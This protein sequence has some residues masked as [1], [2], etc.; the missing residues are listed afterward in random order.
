MDIDNAVCVGTRWARFRFAVIGPLLASVAEHGQLA[1]QL[2]QLAGRT[3]QHPSTGEPVRFSVST[4]ERWYY[5]AKCSPVDPVGAL[6]TKPNAK[7]GT[8]PSIPVLL[9]QAIR[10]QYQ[11]H[12][13]WS[14]QLHYD[15]LVALCRNSPELAPV[16][17]YPTVRR[18]MQSQGL[19]KQRRR[20][21]QKTL[22]DGSGQIQQRETRSYESPYVNALWHLD[23]H[24][25]S[26]RVLTAEGHYV[27]PYL[28][29]V[30]DDH[31]RLCP[32]LQWY[33]EQTA[34]WL[35]HALSQAFLKR[36]LCRV[37]LTDNGSAMIAAETVQGL[38][39]LGICH[40]TTLPRSPEQNGKQEV[41][42]AQVEGRL[43]PM[44]EGEKPLTLELLNR[45]THAWVEQEYNRKVHSETGQA[46]LGRFLNDKNVSRPCPDADTLRKYF[47]AQQRRTQ[48]LSDG[49]VSAMGVRFE[50]PWRYRTLQHPT[51]RF[52]RWDL[53]SIDLVDPHTDKLLCT[54]YPIDK[55]QNAQERRRPV[56]PA[57]EVHLQPS[58]A[59]DA[60]IAPLLRQL[61]ADYAATG[62]PP[63]YLPSEPC[64]PQSTNPADDPNTDK[65]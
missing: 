42:W 25:G 1:E 47:R 33:L 48:R 13:K 36:D 11:Q 29:A 49:T 14:Y 64:Q 9:G 62:L 39:R 65:E 38:S 58:P 57:A 26:R 16:P 22:S 52:A 45:A 54:L 30:L 3:W 34:Q 43:M 53:S 28:M 6:G 60:G 35:V 7:S 23:F 44:L 21:H 8:H 12:P 4:I 56:E 10:N 46:P 24:D 20:A 40:V 17:S 31:S 2:E 18:F 63:A 15:N 19:I 59:G 41:F 5:C 61:M 37:L 32:H 27:K 50:L 51:V 55:N